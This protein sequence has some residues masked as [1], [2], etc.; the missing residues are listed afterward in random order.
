[1]IRSALA[2]LALLAPLFA[3]PAARAASPIEPGEWEQVMTISAEG[4]P[5]GP[6]QKTARAC[7]TSEDAAIFSDGKRWA[8]QMVKANPEAKCRIA[9]TKHEGSAMSVV[10][11][12]EG[13]VRLT[14]R[15]DFQGKAGTIDA[16]TAV[17][18]V[19][20]GTNHIVSKKV[21]D[22]CSPETIEQWK[23]QNPGRTFAP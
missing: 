21:A 22:T 7:I 15:H 19:V 5:H 14:V 16:E 23:H 10:L 4:S 12:C 6:M 11:A 3:V 20:K 1:M 2:A 8:D 18:G 13:D 9:D 17:G